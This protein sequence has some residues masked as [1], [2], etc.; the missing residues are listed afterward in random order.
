MRTRGTFRSLERYLA[1][2]VMALGLSACGQYQLDG[3]K[4]NPKFRDG[5]AFLLG[6][7]CT[8]CLEA[9]HALIA[10]VSSQAPGVIWKG[11]FET[12][13]WSQFSSN[14][15]VVNKPGRLTLVSNPVAQGK[16]AA[17]FVVM[18]GD[19]PINASGDRAELVA[20]SSVW[21]VEG[22]ERWY[23]WQ[24]MFASDF[25]TITKGWQIFLQ[26]HHESLYGGSPPLA[27]N[28]V[29]DT[30]SVSIASKVKNDVY[31]R[32]NLG[33]L[34]RGVWRDFVFHVKWSSN[35]SVGFIEL[36]IDGQ[37][38]IPKTYIYTMY[39]GSKNYM[40]MGLYR[41]SGISQAGTLWHDGMTVG[42]TRQAVMGSSPSQPSDPAQP[43]PTQPGTPSLPGPVTSSPLPPPVLP[44]SGPIVNEIVGLVSSED[45]GE[46]NVAGFAIDKRPET[47]WA[48]LG[49]GCTL[50]ADLGENRLLS[51]I[52]IAWHQGDQRSAWFDVS[53]SSDGG[54]FVPIYS[55]QSSG[56]TTGYEKYS[57]QPVAARYVR[58][59]AN[60]N[61]MNEWNGISE[62]RI[63]NTQALKPSPTGSGTATPIVLD[64]SSV[65]AS[66][67]VPGYGPA[68]A[69]DQSL[70][71]RW[72]CAGLGCW[73]RADTGAARTLSAVQ[74][75]WYLGNHR[76]YYFDISVSEDGDN[77]RSVYRGK[78]T[79]RSSQMERYSFRA[80][81]ARYVK[82][83][84]NGNSEDQSVAINEL[85]IL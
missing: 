51:E 38:A 72:H 69:V 6:G 47:R 85:K 18:N 83:T 12:G 9:K 57:F 39:S 35:P 15:H 65:R 26:W 1:V 20:P 28:V 7:G 30:M 74:I 80:T 54:N 59:V 60:G 77:F 41:S 34:K 68:N 50:T 10:P 61:T 14:R 13:N 53:V 46:G 44:P 42:T 58:V 2:A 81:R 37:L 31:R 56:T 43:G 4:K 73:L 5:D 79:G 33:R 55:G 82:I 24:T 8:S 78:S 66:A 23:R 22:Q 36:Y 32:F 3:L 67:F 64:G 45:D 62:L 49:I 25:P 84:V 75:A 70:S 16:Y 71:T 21:E 11:D 40:K 48:C 27:F 19:D 52:E 63:A 17:K 29:D 76:V